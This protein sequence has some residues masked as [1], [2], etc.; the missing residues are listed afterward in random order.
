MQ[1]NQNVFGGVVYDGATA[2]GTI[3][4]TVDKRVPELVMPVVPPDASFAGDEELYHLQM[5]RLQTYAKDTPFTKPQVQNIIKNLA[6]IE[7]LNADKSSDRLAAL[8]LV[9]KASNVDY[10]TPDKK[11]VTLTVDNLKQTIEAKLITLFGADAFAP[12]SAVQ[13]GVQLEQ[14]EDGA[15]VPID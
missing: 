3:I 1:V 6:L 12:P 10:F 13:F 2:Q 5:M 8:T 9:G 7:A 11:E 4:E 15:F 14:A